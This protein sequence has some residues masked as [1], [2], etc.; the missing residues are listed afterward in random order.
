MAKEAF[1][2]MSRDYPELKVNSADQQW[3]KPCLVYKKCAQEG[4]SFVMYHPEALASSFMVS[5]FGNETHW[6]LMLWHPSY[7]ITLHTGGT[8][9]GA[10]SKN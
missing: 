8:E 10:A 9:L 3:Y 7:R 4:G 2:M 1:T 5:Q 6:M